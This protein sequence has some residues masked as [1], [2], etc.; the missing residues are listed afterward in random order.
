MKQII[1]A[2]FNVYIP[3]WQDLPNMQEGLSLV[4]VITF[5]PHLIYKIKKIGS[6]Y[7][8]KKNSF[9]LSDLDYLDSDF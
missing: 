1:P 3:K 7:D 5:T 9:L 2:Q 6:A 8:P 4:F